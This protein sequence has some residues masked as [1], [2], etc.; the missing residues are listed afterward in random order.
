MIYHIVPVAF[1]NKSDD[2]TPYQSSDFDREGFIH[3]TGGVEQLVEVANRHY[4]GT[5]DEYYILALDESELDSEVRW[6]LA[7]E[8]EF[9]HIYGVINRDAVKD[10]YLFPRE[11]DGSF[12]LP[13]E[14]AE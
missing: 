9:P 8:Q 12:S 11:E 5:P 3:C 10:V 7:G 2:G 1:W 14:L 13:P 6:E 4:Q